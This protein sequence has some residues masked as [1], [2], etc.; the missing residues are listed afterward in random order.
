MAKHEYSFEVQEN[1]A[2]AVGV[3]LSISQKNAIEIAKKIRGKN[4]ETAKEMS[5]F[6][7]RKQITF[8]IAINPETSVR[9]IIPFIPLISHSSF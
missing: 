1:M 9:K 6:L 4:V 7:R 5:D 3:D 2:K 8:G